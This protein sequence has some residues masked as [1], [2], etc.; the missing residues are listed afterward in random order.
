RRG[1][2][3]FPAFAQVVVGGANRPGREVVRVETLGDHGA[4][5]AVLAHLEDTTARLALRAGIHPVGGELVADPLDRRAGAERLAAGDA[6]EGLLLL[7][8]PA[9]HIPGGDVDPRRE[10]DDLLRAGGGTKAALDAEA[11]GEAQHR[12]L[13]VVG[14]GTGRTDRGAGEAER[15]AVGL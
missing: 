6:V 7:H 12:P 2:G 11:L 13:R 4:D 1:P 5:P 8:H 9:R 10:G 15:A 14:E 3:R